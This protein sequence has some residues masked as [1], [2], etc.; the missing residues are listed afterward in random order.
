MY[1]RNLQKSVKTLE[2]ELEPNKVEFMDRDSFKKF[3]DNL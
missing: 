2:A 3:A 1:F